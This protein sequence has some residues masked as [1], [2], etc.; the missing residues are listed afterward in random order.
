MPELLSIPLPSIVIDTD[1]NPRGTIDADKLQPLVDSI[2]LYGVLQPVVVREAPEDGVYV[3][4][5]GQRRYTAAGI[6]GLAEIPAVL[7]ENVNGDARAISLVENLQREQLT[8]IEEA[9]AFEAAIHG[10]LT[11]GELAT[12]IS[13]SPEFVKDRLALLALPETVQ[14]HIGVGDLTLRAAAALKVLAPAGAAIVAKTAELLAAGE[15]DGE[16]IT[17]KDVETDT[18]WVLDQAIAALGTDAP[19]LIDPH[20]LRHDFASIDWPEGSGGGKHLVEKARKLPEYVN[21]RSCRGDALNLTSADLD[22]ARAYGALLEFPGRGRTNGY[23]INDAPWL[24][25]RINEK[26][27]KAIAALEKKTKTAAKKAGASAKDV[28]NVKSDDDAARLERQA[29][30]AEMLAARESN[31]KLGIDLYKELHAPEP[32]LD[33]MQLVAGLLLEYAGEDLGRRG[34]R[35]T[36]EASQKVTTRKDGTIS[37]VTHLRG[38]VEC[39]TLLQER[40]A[41]ATTP[42]Q[43]L[44]VLLQ[45]IVASELADVGAAPVSDRHGRVRGLDGISVTDLELQALVEKVAEPVL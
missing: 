44:G 10:G 42:Q 40:L 24:A 15:V 28:A 26:L 22:A 8:P 21:G 39:R 41:K 43:V 16:S 14:E 23:W 37:R 1:V 12:A 3:L 29:Q 17:T 25:D 36:D 11:P 35:Y 30:H 20:M 7:R 4:L 2:G 34:L 5:A 6:A 38:V 19:F 13:R 45:A 31:V 18:S 27:D 32:T 33:N 9:R